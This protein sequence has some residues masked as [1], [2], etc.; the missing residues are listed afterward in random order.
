[1]HRAIGAALITGA[2]MV[3]PATVAEAATHPHAA[4]QVIVKYEPGA[5]P[6]LRASLANAAGIVER[7]GS[8]AGVGAQVVR[9]AGD[10]EAAAARLNRSQGVLYAEPDLILK[11]S[12]T[13][14]DPRFGELYGLNNA[15]DAD[16]DAPEGWDLAGLGAFPATGGARV[17]IVDTG[18]DP[19]HEDLVG[20][21]VV[22]GGVTN[23]GLLG[24][25]GVNPAITDGSKCNDDNDHGS[26]VAGTIAAIA[27]NGKGVAGVAFN[28]QL[29]ICKAL[30]SAGS[31]PTSGVA[32][33][34]TYLKNK[35]ARIISMSLGGGAST[36]LQQAVQNAYANGNGALIVAAAGNDGNATLSY[37]AAYPE[38]VSVAATDSNDQRASFSNANGDV[39]V[40]AAGVNVLSVKRG[41]GYVAFSGTSMATPHA[42]GVAALIA[43]RFPSLNAAGIRSRLDAGTDDLGAAGR[44]PSFGFGRVTLTKALQ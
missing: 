10:P 28:S 31:G 33:C 40:A 38:A 23:F 26:H 17:G 9:V 22:C 3:G 42:A 35:G 24:I 1:M 11:A 25:I 7:V 34:I 8:V 15:N 41:G 4:H 5:S 36:T 27:N 29:A 32:N 6:S 30:N 13:P 20:K 12:A 43:G 14:N 16:L 37:P 2:A 39:E 18:S 19:N 21:R 44:D